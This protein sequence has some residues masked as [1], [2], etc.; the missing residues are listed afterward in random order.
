[1]SA[2]IAPLLAVIPSCTVGKNRSI[3]C[4]RAAALWSCTPASRVA[5]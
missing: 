1:M 4:V 3:S 2:R 5:M